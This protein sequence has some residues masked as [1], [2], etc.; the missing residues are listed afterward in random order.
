MTDEQAIAAARDMYASDDVE[1]DDNPKLS[2]ADDGVWVAAW[3]W[4]SR[5]DA[6]HDA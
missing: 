6:E 5:E 4:V 1:I 3:V 2:H